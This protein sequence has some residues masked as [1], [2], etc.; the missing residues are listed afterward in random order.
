MKAGKA[1]SQAG[2]AYVGALL[3]ALSADSAYR[4]QAQQYVA[5]QP[6]TKVALTG[7]LSRVVRAH[8]QA[9]AAG[10]PSYL[11]V[12][13]G[14]SDFYNGEPTVTAWGIGPLTRAQARPFV[15]RFQSL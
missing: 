2:H 15:K 1:A 7:T 12:D 10:L 4:E 5:E 9:L 11:V 14:C 3:Q 13:Q 6:G 8:E